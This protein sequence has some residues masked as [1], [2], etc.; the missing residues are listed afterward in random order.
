WRRLIAYLDDGTY[1]IDN[2]AAERSIRPFTIG[3][4]NW[5]FAKSQAGASASANL[6]SLVETAKA[7]GLNPYEYLKTIFTELPNCAEES[8]SNLL[9]W[10]ITLG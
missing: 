3:R 8:L 10:N 9:P 5:M 4:K 1:P 7:N 2:N 6:Y